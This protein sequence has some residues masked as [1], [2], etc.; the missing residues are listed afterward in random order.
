MPIIADLA[1]FLSE[2]DNVPLAIFAGILAANGKPPIDA[3][4]AVDTAGQ[5]GHFDALNAGLADGSYPLCTFG[6]GRVPIVTPM[7]DGLKQTLLINKLASY[8]KANNGVEA[9]GLTA[10]VAQAEISE[11]PDPFVKAWVAAKQGVGAAPTPASVAQGSDSAPPATPAAPIPA[12]HAQLVVPPE[13]A[14]EMPVGAVVSRSDAV[15]TTI[16]REGHAVVADVKA[17]LARHHL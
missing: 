14:A 12:G 2:P 10:L 11:N 17:F 4:G 9:Q 15:T 13:H 16:V 1:R 7:S 6:A 3:S 8:T 5:Q